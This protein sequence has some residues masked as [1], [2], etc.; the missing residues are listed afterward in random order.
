MQLHELF[1]GPGDQPGH[2]CRLADVGFAVGHTAVAGSL[3]A[4]LRARIG[5][6]KPISTRTIPMTNPMAATPNATTDVN[7]EACRNAESSRSTD[8]GP[9]ARVRRRSFRR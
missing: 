7:S 3:G 9:R 5:M 6:A 1:R 4:R 8:W 2:A